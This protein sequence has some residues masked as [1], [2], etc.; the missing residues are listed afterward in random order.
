ME[1]R[2]GSAAGGPLGQGAREVKQL[3]LP[4]WFSAGVILL[5]AAT[6]SWL[7][8][9]RDLRARVAPQGSRAVRN[10]VIAGVGAVALQLAERPVISRVARLVERRRWGLLQRLPLPVWLSTVAAVV[11]LDYTLYLWHVLAHRSPLLW[12][13]HAVHHIDR[14]LDV[15]TGIRFHFAELMASVPWRAGQVVVI[16]VTPAALSVWQLFL[17]VCVLFHHSNVELP[18]RLERWISRIIVT[19]RMHGIHHSR[20][21]DEMNSNWSSGLTIW[22]R[23]HGTLKLNVPQQSVTIG[24]AGYDGEDDVRLP[25][26]LSLPFASHPVDRHDAEG[27]SVPGVRSDVLLP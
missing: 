25:A 10:L 26:M 3:P 20:A 6:L 18:V 1:L 21:A 4:S 16:G 8:R 24:V 27:R 13:A 19:P 5:T 17:L 22:D 11:L 12:R 14:D 9:R 2:P 23:L 7:E 15:S